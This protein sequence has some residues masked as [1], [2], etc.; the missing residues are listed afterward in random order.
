MF[1][2]KLT[3]ASL[4]ITEMEETSRRLLHGAYEKF[5]NSSSMQLATE[6]LALASMLAS[7]YYLRRAPQGVVK[8]IDEAE[9]PLAEL[10][11]SLLPFNFSKS[12]V[13]LRY[14]FTEANLVR[15]LTVHLPPGFRPDQETSVY[16]LLDGV[17]INNPAGN[18]LGING[19]SRTADARNIVAVNLE[20]SNKS[21]LTAFGMPLPKSLAGRALPNITSW[22][23]E[24]GLLNKTAGVDDVKSFRYMYNL[25]EKSMTV[26]AHNIVAFSDGAPL[27]NA[28]AAQMPERSLNGVANVAGTIMKDAQSPKPGIK[29]LFVNSRH[30]P[31]L[32][33]EGGPGSRL[34]KW[35]PKI[36]HRH[37]I[38]SA[39]ELQPI[40]YAE[41]NGIPLTPKIT[42][43]PIYTQKD[44]LPAAGSNAAVRAFILKKGGHTW[45]GRDIGEAANT[46]F[47]KANGATISHAEFPTNSLIV[48]FLEKRPIERTLD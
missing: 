30:D 28:I 13:D 24:H 18:M 19:W 34:T 31:T 40:R 3:P 45:P 5:H 12:G 22:S 27:A 17:Q 43:T 39:P 20:Q 23:F 37:I 42:E 1:E 35:L 8:L 41:A 36:G 21:S 2:Q 14:Q 33:L 44:Y 6:G 7:V 38:N 26:K 46:A 10:G 4:N 9:Q 48:D 29:A 47:T 15:R 25:I 11:S 16:Y 32:P